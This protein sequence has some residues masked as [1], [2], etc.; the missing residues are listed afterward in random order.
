MEEIPISINVKI[1]FFLKALNRSIQANNYLSVN[2][3]FKLKR[4]HHR[5]H[6][7]TYNVFTID[8]IL[9]PITFSA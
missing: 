5:R 3:I 9:K 8:E 6:I 2:D 7:K 4:F 1:N